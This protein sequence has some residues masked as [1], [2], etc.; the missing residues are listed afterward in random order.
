M[1]VVNTSK[2][3]N[4][5]DN[6]DNNISALFKLMYLTDTEKILLWPP[7]ACLFLIFILNNINPKVIYIEKY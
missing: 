7:H 6:I 5:V 4:N 1:E 2:F 3:I